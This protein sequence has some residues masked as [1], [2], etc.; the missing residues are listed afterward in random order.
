ME[1]PKLLGSALVLRYARITPDVRATGNTRHLEGA[2]PVGGEL[3]G[4]TL[5]P[6]AKALAIAQYAGEENVYLFGL[7]EHGDIQSDTGHETV[8]DALDQADLRVRGAHLDSPVRLSVF[9]DT[10]QGS[11]IG[12]GVER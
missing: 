12:L 2:L 3:V 9:V 1:A 4:G 10:R 6:P 5:I 8:E 7:D 11:L